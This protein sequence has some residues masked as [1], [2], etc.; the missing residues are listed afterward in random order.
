MDLQEIERDCKLMN[1]EIEI[2]KSLNRLVCVAPLLIQ[3]SIHFNHIHFP[4]LCLRVSPTSVKDWVEDC[5]RPSLVLDT[6]P[7]TPTQALPTPLVLV[8]QPSCTE[9]GALLEREEQ[10]EP[11]P[12]PEEEQSEDPLFP[13]RET[14]E[15]EEGARIYVGRIK[16]HQDASG[17]RAAVVTAVDWPLVYYQYEEQVAAKRE[18]NKDAASQGPV[19]PLDLPHLGAVCHRNVAAAS[20]VGVFHRLNRPRAARPPPLKLGADEPQQIGGFAIWALGDGISPI[21][22]DEA[23]GWDSWKGE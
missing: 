9:E 20:S 12:E 22:G 11:E 15:F 17:L 18:Y 7:T 8:D 16:S 19:L 1:A 6:K 23:T 5:T 14:H 10:K 3:I 2:Q 21:G 13:L 4:L